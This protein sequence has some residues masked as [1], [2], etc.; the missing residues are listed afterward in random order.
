MSDCIGHFGDVKLELPVFHVGYFKAIIFILQMICKVGCPNVALAGLDCSPTLP[1]SPQN[2]SRVMITGADRRKFL[3]KLRNPN[4][5]ML[6]RRTNLK[7]V[8]HAHELS[9]GYRC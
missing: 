3:R 7:K 2:C 5:E 9:A 4:A 8:C 6:E 1:L